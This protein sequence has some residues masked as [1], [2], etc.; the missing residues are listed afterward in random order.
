MKLSMSQRSSLVPTISRVGVL[1]S[2]VTSVA[3]R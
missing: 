1:V 3:H 2:A